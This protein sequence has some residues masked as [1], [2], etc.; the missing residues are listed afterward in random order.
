MRKGERERERA[1]LVASGP[2][3][4]MAKAA[5]VASGA[6]ASLLCSRKLQA[7]AKGQIKTMMTGEHSQTHT[8]F[9]GWMEG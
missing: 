8:Q 4:S 6:V 5:R 3:W 9:A 2:L 7:I 1:T